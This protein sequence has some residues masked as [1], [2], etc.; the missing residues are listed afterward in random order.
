MCKIG[1]IVGMLL[2]TIHIA[3]AQIKKHRIDTMAV[4]NLPD[5]TV[6]GKSSK[7]DY[8]QMPE[9]VG[10]NIYAGKKNALIVLDNVQG[11][12]VTNN[13]RQVL[14]KVP[15]IHIWES[16]P[17][18]IQIGIAARGLSPNRSW[19]FNVRQN[20]YDI[21]ADPFGYPE[22][23]Y[24]PQLQ[25]VQRIE[26]VRGQAALQYGPQFGGLVNYILRNG[27]ETNKPVE[28]E[29][30][31]TVGSNG[32]FNS[33]N[34]IG[35]KKGNIHYYTFFDHRNAD[36]WRANSRYFTNAGY[37]TVSYQV[38]PKFSLTAEI[39]RSHIRSQQP[40]GLTDMQIQQDAGQSLRS[41]NW[42]DITWTTPAIIANYQ[43][44]N[45]TRW[46][47]KLFG[48]VGD[49]NSVGFLQSITTK[50]SINPATVQYNNRLVNLDKYRNYGVESRFITDYSIG[51]M[52]N[53]VSMGVRLYT[54]TTTRQ[55]DGKGTTGTGYDIAISGNYPRDIMFTSSNA[56]LFVEHIFR[57]ADRWMII[58][59]IRY[60]WLKGSSAGRNG[61]TSGGTEITLQ[62]ISRDRSFILTGL[63]TEYQIT[64]STKLYAN[65][66]QAYRPIQ[67]ANLQAP[68]TTDVVDPDL[69]DAK[70][71]N[72]DLGYRGKLKDFLQFDISGFYLQY[73]NRVGTISVSG[74][75]SYRLIT[76]VG[77]STSKGFE[78]YVELNAIRAFD[79]SQAIDL[80]IFGS[81]GYTNA[82]YSGDHKDASTKG[83]QVENAPINI[84][85]GGLTGGYKGLLVTV[86][87]SSVGASF[88]DANNTVEP[89]T[90]GNTGR[91]PAYTV[92]DLT[93]TYK[94]LKGL[95][96][97]AGINNLLDER[98][99]TRRAGGYPGPG[100]LPADGR[101]FF[102]SVGAKL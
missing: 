93:A 92:T 76:N 59:G 29:T 82:R 50:D 24:N 5:I 3:N 68:P 86:Q 91:I 84:F 1:I 45:N 79:K 58:P 99:F 36:G 66:A 54:G 17:S 74:T 31:Q 97:K 44:N 78:G 51:K 14:A 9:I 61:Y 30:Q 16:D 75:P 33:Y 94:F 4:K 102:V 64:Q 73:D 100:A 13:M 40:G 60:E 88:S 53:T 21:A 52:K 47:T 12:V 37:A 101:T 43:F 25:A 80:I 27:S 55:A 26:I 63:G 32:L 10:T 72:I 83:K 87:V 98:Y 19:E 57:I 67:F 71:Y 65:I 89:S 42:F 34:A 95:N 18:G 20:G 46:N 85:R 69:K 77:S 28:F 39:M 11:N 41:R 48:T 81:Y 70:G 38:T 62:N 90:N 56:A 35:G 96:L 2:L 15:G 7:S 22:A 23:Y 8:Q 49:R 6:V